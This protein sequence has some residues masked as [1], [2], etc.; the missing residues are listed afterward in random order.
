MGSVWLTLEQWSVF[1]PGRE[2]NA[3]TL[4]FPLWTQEESDFFGDEPVTILTED[5]WEIEALASGRWG[6]RRP[7][8]AGA[9]K[10][11]RSRPDSAFGE[12][13]VERLGIAKEALPGRTAQFTDTGPGRF[14]ARVMPE[15]WER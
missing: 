4:Y 14:Y 8:Q 13:L 15:G 12:W 3:L 11:L 2:R 5:R 9:R 6:K 7:D 1:E 10:N